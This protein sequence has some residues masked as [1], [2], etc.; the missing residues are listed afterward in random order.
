MQPNRKKI[1]IID[2][3]KFFCESIKDILEQS[4][5]TVF[6]ASSGEDGLYSVTR[7]KPDLVL[8]DVVLAGMDGIE[9]CRMLRSSESNNLMAIIMISA[10]DD[11]DDK[12]LGLEA[13]ADDYIT[14]PFDERELLARIRN[15]LLRIDRSRAANPLTGLPGNLDIQREIDSRIATGNPFAVLYVDLDN[16]KAFND[17]YG[18]AKGDKAIKMTADILRSQTRL[19]GNRD[20]FI[21]HIGGDDFV[22]VTT[23]DKARSICQ[24]VIEKFDAKIRTLFHKQDVARGYITSVNRKGQ[25]EAYPITAISMAI[26]TNE[27]RKLENHMAVAAVASELK[28]IL[29]ALPGSNYIKDRRQDD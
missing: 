22:V 26:I 2:D 9:V 23:P 15:T 5:Y 13:G 6:T 3:S 18:F 24:N 17:V 7:D 28:A 11:M 1:L 14:K 29:K 16:F 12:L 20:D 19:F 21:G 10:Q 27:K 25:T 4:G 8:L